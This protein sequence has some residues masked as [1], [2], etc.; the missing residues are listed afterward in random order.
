MKT[1]IFII[2]LSLVTIGAFSQDFSNLKNQKF[3]NSV[4]YKNA[5]PK[6]LECSNYLL[7]NPIDKDELNRLN[8]FQYVLKWMEGTEDYTFSIG[9]QAMELTKGNPDLLTMYLT[10]MTKTVLDNSDLELS[11]DQV[12]EKATEYLVEYCSKPENNLKPSKK[13]K[14]ILKKK[15]S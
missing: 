10:S 12:Q 5:E 15:N 2:A 6:V 14:K 3:K 13:I 9:E 11:D 4:D 1:S 7:N 8:S